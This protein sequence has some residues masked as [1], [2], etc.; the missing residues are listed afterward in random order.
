MNGQ[1]LGRYSGS[2]TGKL[3]I[4]LDDMGSHYAGNVFAYNDNTSLPHTYAY[5]RTPDKSRSH[6]LC[7]DLAPLH[8][9]TGEAS[10]WN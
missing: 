5:V 2:N 4:N 8:P 9:Q 3:F 7:L 10:N 6:H 1:W